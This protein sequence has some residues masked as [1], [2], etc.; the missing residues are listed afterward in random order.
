[1]TVPRGQSAL[2]LRAGWA[3]ARGHPSAHPPFFTSI[4]SRLP[5]SSHSSSPPILEVSSPV[6]W[7]NWACCN[8]SPYLGG[9][10]APRLLAP[11]PP[12]VSLPLLVR[13]LLAI[14][15][16]HT[17]PWS[18]SS[19]PS[20]SGAQLTQRREGQGGKGE[21]S[22][23]GGVGLAPPLGEPGTGCHDN[24]RLHGSSQGVGVVGWGVGRGPNWELHLGKAF[25]SFPPTCPQFLGK[26]PSPHMPFLITLVHCWPLPQ[27]YP[28][29]PDR[30]SLPTPRQTGVFR[31]LST[32]LSLGSLHTCTL[33]PVISVITSPASTFQTLPGPPPVQGAGFP[34]PSTPLPSP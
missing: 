5:K 1:M 33:L 6:W 11:S 21:G 7:R 23:G 26:H 3:L 27:A 18:L 29:G 28:L 4:S 13:G 2:A 30:F 14:P 20:R 8:P 17:S 9:G 22:G 24:R 10:G 12:E 19:Q 25:S 32:R 34:R 15:H 31:A 16:P